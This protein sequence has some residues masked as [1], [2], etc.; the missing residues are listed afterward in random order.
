MAAVPVIPAFEQGDSH[1]FR[2]Q[3]LSYAVQFA[4]RA[5]VIF[6]LYKT[7]TLPISANVATA[8]T[9]DAAMTDSDGG[10]SAGSPTKYTAQTPGYFHVDY[11][12]NG[13]ETGVDGRFSGF[14]RITTGPNNPAGLGVTS[15]WTVHGDDNGTSATQMSLTGSG[16]TPYLYIG[17]VIEIVVLTTNAVTLSNN[18]NTS[19]NNDL[20]GFP[21]GG[22]YFTG[23]L[24]SLGP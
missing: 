20:N 21:D 1:L 3:Q 23:M 6:H 19:G 2:L 5:P 9:W 22:A 13:N 10:W 17:D 14:V 7:G 16:L 15:T 8:V 11:G 18:W 12:V 4:C 24:W